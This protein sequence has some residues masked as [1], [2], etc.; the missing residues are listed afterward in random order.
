[1]PLIKPISGKLR[2]ASLLSSILTCTMALAANPADMTSLPVPDGCAL[3]ETAS[4]KV[5]ASPAHKQVFPPVALQIRTVIAPTAFASGGRNYLIYELDLQNYSDQTM[6]LRAIEVLDASKATARPIASFNQ[7]QLKAQLRPIG[8]D[9]WQYHAH[10]HGDANRKL[11]TGQSAVA[12]LCL[13]FE[14]KQPMPSQLR[15][16]VHLENDSTDGPLIPVQLTPVPVFGGPLTGG[17]WHPRNGPH[18]DSHHRMGLVVTDGLAQNSRRFAIDWRKQ[19]D[20]SQ[21]VGDARDV[22]AYHAYG[23]NVLAVAEGTVV[24]ARDGYPDNIPRTAAGFEPALPITMENLGG[25]R[26]VVQLHNGQFAQYAHL[27]AGSVKV[28]QGQQLVRGQLIGLVGNSG[29]SR[30][31]HLHFQLTNQPDLFASEGLPYVIEQFRMKPAG[32]EWSTRTQE[33]PW[34]DDTVIDFG[35]AVDRAEAGLG[36]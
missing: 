22:R 13:A 8:M 19:K 17:D 32:T 15:H 18:L 4:S 7:S 27:Q 33:F 23:E 2:A 21:Y 3:A 30:V 1:M 25:N 12:F 6:D 10:P 28:K 31:P 34:G 35:P 14:G 24:L 9:H 5:A 16:R 20:G 11:G 36:R 26:V 29:D